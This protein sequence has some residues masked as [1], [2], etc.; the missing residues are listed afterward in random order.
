MFSKTWNPAAGQYGALAFIYG[1]LV[2]GVIAVVIAVPLSL[3][4]A[5]AAHRGGVAPRGPADRVR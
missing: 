3:G 2:T 1:T 5:L 4:I